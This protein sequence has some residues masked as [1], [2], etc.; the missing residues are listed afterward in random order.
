ME[1][2][3]SNYKTAW[4]LHPQTFNFPDYLEFQEDLRDQ[5][6]Y[7]RKVGIPKN[8]LR[9]AWEKCAV[10]LITF[11]NWLPGRK[12]SEINERDGCYFIEIEKKE[13]EEI[14]AAIKQLSQKYPEASGI[15]IK[16]RGFYRV[17]FYYEVAHTV[18]RSGRFLFE[19]LR[20]KATDKLW[21]PWERHR[22]ERKAWLWA[23]NMARRKNPKIRVL[24][25][26]A[27]E[28]KKLRFHHWILKEDK[29]YRIELA[30]KEKDQALKKVA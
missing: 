2:T 29:K 23:V 18:A 1:K 12:N 5:F 24:Y 26:A 17:I 20:I 14:R 3:S 30:K 11:T 15:K 10:R 25:R 27:D 16:P 13:S 8:D 21:K 19:F 28:K 22:F 4:Y 6:R 7:L 9:E